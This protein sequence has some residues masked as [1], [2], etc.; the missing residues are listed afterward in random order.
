MDTLT[1]VDM[2]LDALLPFVSDRHILPDALIRVLL[3]QV[4]KFG[5]SDQLP[6]NR[7]PLVRIA[8]ERPECLRL[9]L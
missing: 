6:L 2:L 7:D 4:A 3:S 9:S 5:K 8:S 1:D